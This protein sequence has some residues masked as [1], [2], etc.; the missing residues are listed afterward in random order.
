MSR[1]QIL[2]CSREFLGNSLRRCS[3]NAAVVKNIET[4]ENV[5]EKSCDNSERI[6]KENKSVNSGAVHLKRSKAFQKS[7]CGSQLATGLICIHC[8]C[9]KTSFIHFIIILPL[10]LTKVRFFL[11]F[12]RF[13]MKSLRYKARVRV[14]LF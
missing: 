13:V 7:E 1:L 14:I 8:L 9:L 12:F 5:S 6:F 3:N 4:T 11:S 2:L 10:F